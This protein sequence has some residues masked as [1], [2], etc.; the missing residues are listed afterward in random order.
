[1]LFRIL[2]WRGEVHTS[3]AVYAGPKEGALRS[4]GNLVMRND[5]FEAFRRLTETEGAM[6]RVEFVDEFVEPAELGPT[7][8]KKG[9]R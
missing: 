2:F 4:C 8:P 1:V 9:K 5:E 6:L 3:L 7:P